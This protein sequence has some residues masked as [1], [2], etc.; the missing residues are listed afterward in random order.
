LKFR[1]LGRSGI[2]V[3]QLCLGS[4]TWGTQNT[5]AEGHQQMDMAFEAGINI[6]DTAEM[7]PTTPLGE[8]T[9]GRSE[10][11]IGSWCK[12]RGNRDS[13]L[14]ATKVTGDGPRYIH[15]GIPIS[16]Q[17][18]Q[19]ALEGSLRR[20]QTDYI[21]L[22]QLHWPNRGS[23][24]FR[25]WPG[26]SPVQQDTAAE[27]DNMHRVLEALQSHIAAGRIRHIGLSN[28][29]CWGASQYLR[30]SEQFDL[31]RMV[32]TQNEYSL[33][34]R[35]FDL[36]MAELSHHE[37]LGLLAWSPLAAGLLSGKY[38]SG[39]I[40]AGS[41]RNLNDTLNGRLN[42][43]SKVPL[44]R[45]IDIAMQHGIAPAQ[46]AIAYCMTRPFMTSVIIGAT[47]LEQLQTNIG[48]A[49]LTLPES[50]IEAIEAVHRQYPMPM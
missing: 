15:D 29:S 36:D 8:E 10:E 4:M 32:T 44:Q 23:Y 11:I 42:D 21:D 35:L 25:Q 46:L 30:L 26:Y 38:A 33:L 20:L 17:K 24:H 16:P 50:A 43:Y 45:Y 48:A 28:E 2:E 9:Q 39:D 49:E 18:I 47:N 41:R 6:I 1:Q 40:P 14:I 7:Y 5:E 31:P 37:E 22:Y 13:V 19:L 12:A 3:S 34:C 27:L